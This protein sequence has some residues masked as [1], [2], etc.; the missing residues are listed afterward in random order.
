VAKVFGNISQ[1]NKSNNVTIQVVTHI[2]KLCE[3]QRL[4][5]IC[6]AILVAKAA[7]RTFIKLFQISIVIKSLSL[8]DFNFFNSLAPNF[9]CFKKASTLCSGIDIKAVS[10][11][12]KNADK[13]NKTKKINIVTGSI[14]LVLNEKLKI[15]IE[16]IIRFS[17]IF[18]SST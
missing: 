11:P 18:S 7:V 3:D 2:A 13:R 12:E 1:N 4:F 9:L 6:I 14:Y 16:S 5:E 17:I 15:I 8:L 10:L